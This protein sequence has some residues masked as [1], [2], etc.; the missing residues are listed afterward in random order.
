MGTSLELQ[1]FD[2]VAEFVAEGSELHRID[3][4]VRLFNDEVGVL[5][6][7]VP[8][9]ARAAFQSV[10]SVVGI[11]RECVAAAEQIVARTAFQSIDASPAEENIVIA[12]TKQLIIA[13]IAKNDVLV[14]A[15]DQDVIKVIAVD[16]GH[17]ESP[18]SR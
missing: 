18:L 1:V 10:G 17:W 2:V 8:I 14:V 7:K 5:D 16:C 6:D 13:A 3:A 12:K 4:F 15:A 9:V 11:G